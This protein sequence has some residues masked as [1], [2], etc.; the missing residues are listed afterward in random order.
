MA[1]GYVMLC[2]NSNIPCSICTKLHMFGKS[3]GL[4]TST[5]QCSVIGI[6]PPAGSR[7]FGTY[8]WLWHIPPIFTILRAYCPPFAVFLK[9]PVGGE[10]GCEVP[11]IAAC[12]LLL[13]LLLLL[14]SKLNRIFEGLNMLEKS[15]NFA[16]APEVAKI[17]IWYGF[18]K[19]VWQMARQ[20]HLYTF[21][22][23]RL[24]LQFHVHVWKSVHSCN[25]PIPT[26]KSLEAKSQTQQEVGY[27]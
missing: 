13:L 11:F 18:Q 21:N 20:R 7:K 23:V 1:T 14:F 10:P 3:P 26:K 9:P 25:T 6:A 15:R 4:K 5:C 19:W 12:S 22:G 8:K 27:F 17:Y 2:T 24:K 16:H